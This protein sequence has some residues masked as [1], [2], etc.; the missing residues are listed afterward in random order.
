MTEGVDQTSGRG[1]RAI[2]TRLKSLGG[3]GTPEGVKG[4]A[5]GCVKIQL[6]M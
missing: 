6:C 5:I 1:K 2:S 3:E 4:I